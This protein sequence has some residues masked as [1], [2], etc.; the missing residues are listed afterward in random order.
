MSRAKRTEVASWVA[1]GV[2]VSFAVGLRFYAIERLPGIN[3]DEPQYAVHA[4][5]FFAGA[6]LSALRTGSDLPMNPVFFG[7]VVILQ[8]L[9][10]PT[11]WSLRMSAV[12]LSLATIALAW[13]LTRQRGAIFASTF[14]CLVAVLPIHLAY[15][16]FAWDPTAIPTVSLLALAASSRRRIALCL[17]AF[18][19]CLWVHPTT[20]F[21]APALVT[22]FLTRYWA[23][24]RYGRWRWSQGQVLGAALGLLVLPLTAAVMQLAL[25]R[26]W[27]PD[28]VAGVL[29]GDLLAD[30]WHR[31]K[32][33]A[34]L[35]RFL[36]AYLELLAGPTIYRYITGS[37]STRVGQVHVWLGAALLLPLVAAGLRAAVLRGRTRDVAIALG[38]VLSLLLVYLLAGPVA[39][40]PKTERYAVCLTVPACYVL[41]AC[42]DA[43]ATTAAR[44]RLLRL[45]LSVVAG[46]L[47]LSFTSQY[48]QRLKYPDPLRE[49]TF[50]TGETEPKAL[51]LQ[52]IR[53]LRDPAK[54][55][56]IY[57][58]DWWIYWTFRYL[59]P[60]SSVPP[61]RVTIHRHAW[62]YRFPRD[63]W[64]P[65]FDAA[66]MQAFGVAW[67]GH[68]TDA[69]F[70][71]RATER[72]EIFGYD[73]GAILRV[74]KLPGPPQRRRARQGQ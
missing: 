11:L 52:T 69:S 2:C 32:D 56:V 51:A 10:A 26:N 4:H 63:F 6:P 58:E 27:L 18:L 60:P 74:Y 45:G 1:L 17:G 68:S 30:A 49:D 29:R 38:L 47:L 39:L 61:I 9:F 64:A 13:A 33:P 5:E 66:R 71:R 70:A 23:R 65:D 73:F 46:A 21:L 62:D 3:G 54:M 42:V 14:A 19:L 40:A 55:A 57:V 20:V 34:Q 8:M 12:V 43:L 36:L 15:A 53:E 25:E 41:S 24:D 67:A 37:I 16:R 35:G 31:A 7:T 50:R 44:A 59:A 48:L 72:R 22:P 28:A